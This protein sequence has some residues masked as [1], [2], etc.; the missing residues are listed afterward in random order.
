M[1]GRIASFKCVLALF[2]LSS[3]FSFATERQADSNEKPCLRC[4]CGTGNTREEARRAIDEAIEDND[5]EAFLRASHSLTKFIIRDVL[6][7]GLNVCFFKL[8]SSTTLPAL[9]ISCEPNSFCINPDNLD[10]HTYLVGFST[11]IMMVGVIPSFVAKAITTA[12]D[13]YAEAK[14]IRH[15]LRAPKEE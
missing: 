9:E 8:I 10:P 7:I 1:F 13:C 3:Q 2:L 15:S 12:R 6:G 4:L 11:G 5:K 14:A